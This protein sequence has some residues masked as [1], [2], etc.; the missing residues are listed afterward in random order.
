MIH[1]LRS[2]FPSGQ[3]SRPAARAAKASE[4]RALV[5]VRPATAI[6]AKAHLSRPSAAFL[7]QL[8]ATAQQTPQ[9][10]EKRRVEPEAAI[11]IYEAAKG[12]A[13]AGRTELKGVA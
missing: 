3:G 2:E 11:A 10:R 6:K 12:K 8:I 1:S 9:T 4:E 5:P 7:A 13:L